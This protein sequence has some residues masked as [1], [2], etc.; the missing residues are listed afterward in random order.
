M[1]IVLPWLGKTPSFC[2]KLAQIEKGNTEISEIIS[3]GEI[4]TG[5]DSNARCNKGKPWLMSLPCA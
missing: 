1:H 3:V 4:K 2:D 5:Q